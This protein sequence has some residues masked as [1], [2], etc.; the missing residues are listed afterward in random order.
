MVALVGDNLLVRF[1]NRVDLAFQVLEELPIAIE[2][3][4]RH[5]AGLIPAPRRFE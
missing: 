2:Q 4:S 1:G 5:I 3:Q